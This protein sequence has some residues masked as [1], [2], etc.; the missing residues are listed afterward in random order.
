MVAGGGSARNAE[1]DKRKDRAKLY[2]DTENEYRTQLV[3]EA[4]PT[5]TRIQTAKAVS[6]C[7]SASGVGTWQCQRYKRN[8]PKR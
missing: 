8:A 6:T 2:T 3:W 1:D 4:V 5:C 7:T